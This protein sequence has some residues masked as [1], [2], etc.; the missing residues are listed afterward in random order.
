M[1]L[2]RGSSR[3]ETY[4]RWHWMQRETHDIDPV[5]PVLRQ[6]TGRW[7]PDDRAW[8]ILLYV[9]YY[10]LGSALKAI[11]LVPD[12]AHLPDPHDMAD[13]LL[14]LPCATERRGHRNRVKLAAHLDAI[15]AEALKYRPSGVLNQGNDW[16]ALVEYLT[17]I[18]G[19]GRWA[20]YKLAELAQKVTHREIEVTDAA[21]AYSSGPRK[22]LADV[23]GPV[24]PGN[25][26]ATVAL[27]D[28][29]TEELAAYVHEDDLGYVE[30][31]L[32]DF[33]SLVSGRYYLGHDIDQMQDQ[34][35][36]VPSALTASAFHARKLVLPKEY[37]GELQGWGGVD[38]GRCGVYARRGEIVT[39]S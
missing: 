25:D 31:S 13:E 24:P 14:S 7:S 9:A 39:R 5:Y 1:H 12:P 18:R 32:C 26:P 21:H 37:L 6:L 23:L 19:N 10:H 35:N 33:H 8:L 11:E 3:P 28:K 15:A 30:T 27:L 22:G 16:N 36:A 4:R 2:E 38:K 29:A 20:S 34:L 17:T